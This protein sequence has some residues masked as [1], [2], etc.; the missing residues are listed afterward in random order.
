MADGPGLL[1]MTS[2]IEGDPI[3]AA[4]RELSRHSVRND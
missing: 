2:R 1:M 4:R 3:D